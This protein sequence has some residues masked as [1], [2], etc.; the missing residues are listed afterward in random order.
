MNKQHLFILST[1]NQTTIKIVTPFL[2]NKLG[3]GIK[4][5]VGLY[6]IQLGGESAC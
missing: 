1:K 2:H 6:Y 4:Y 5:M 3:D